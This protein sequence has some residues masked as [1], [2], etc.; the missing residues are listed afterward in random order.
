M[1]RNCINC[2]YATFFEVF[3]EKQLRC[4]EEPGMCDHPMCISIGEGKNYVCE[5]H[6]TKEEFEEVQFLCAQNR[7]EEIE[8]ERKRIL[9]K[10]PSLNNTRKEE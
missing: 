8:A 2:A 3:K 10:Y 1:K 6:K 9:E 7:L 4:W 5:N